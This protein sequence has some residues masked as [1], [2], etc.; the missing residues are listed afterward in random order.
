MSTSGDWG[1]DLTK[2]WWELN[3]PR[4]PGK[5]LAVLRRWLPPNSVLCFQE[6]STTPEIKDFFSRQSIPTTVHCGYG[7][8]VPVTEETISE[9]IEIMDHHCGLDLAQH[10]H[11]YGDGETFLEWFDAWENL[12]MRLA[13]TI[14]EDRIALLARRFGTEYRREHY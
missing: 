1:V 13:I 10:V 4:D 5:F 3:G 7:G 9:L 14:S 6:G 2:G 12:P 8:H 11:V